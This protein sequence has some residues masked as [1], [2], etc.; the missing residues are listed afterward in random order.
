METDNPFTT[1]V[2]DFVAEYGVSESTAQHAVEM[3]LGVLIDTLKN[4]PDLDTAC[5][6]DFRNRIQDAFMKG[7]EWAT[8]FLRKTMAKEQGK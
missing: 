6:T 2:N 8:E 5:E 7:D 3:F 1:L 4:H